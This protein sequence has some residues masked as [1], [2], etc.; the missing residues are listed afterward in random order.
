MLSTEAGRLVVTRGDELLLSVPAARVSQVVVIAGA[1]V[2]MPTL[3]M[4]LDRRV[5]LVFLTAGGAF[6]GRLSG[7]LSR[8][9]AVRRRQYQCAE[10]ED[11]CL[12]I[13]RALVNG[14]LRNCRTLCLRLD[15]SNVDEV[16]LAAAAAIR[17]LTAQAAQAT[18]RPALMGIEGRAAR[19]Y[20][21]VFGHFLRPPWTFTRRLRR[22][23]PDPVN[24]V[25]SLVY[26]LLHESC[27]AALETAGLDPFCGFLHAPHPGRASLAVDLMEEFRP[28]IADSVVLTLLNKRML[29]PSDFRRGDDGGVYLE[30]EGWRA[31]AT[32]YA[33]R[34]ET[35]VL[36]PDS[37]R[38]TT[39]QKLL[40]VQA[41][42]LRRVVLGEAHH[43]EPFLSK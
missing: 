1:G 7:D 2:T 10:D 29:A 6:R 20:F 40:E 35:R 38:R 39:Y 14:K 30:R 41:R 42:Q 21:R 13:G 5:P 19:E 16:T 4:L 9:V 28:I 24:A 23:P 43:Y 27:Y 26:T 18:T 34:M 32:Q 3:G 22:P 33:R 8:H 11:F 12:D 15:T 17:A 37:E 25:L 36:L 31:V